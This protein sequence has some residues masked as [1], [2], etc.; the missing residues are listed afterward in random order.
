M[1]YAAKVNNAEVDFGVNMLVNP[2]ELDTLT[3]G[4]I[5]QVGTFQNAAELEFLTKFCLAKAVYNVF[6]PS[7]SLKMSGIE[8]PSLYLPGPNVGLATLVDNSGKFLA[9][10]VQ[11]ALQSKLPGLFQGPL[12]RTIN[13]LLWGRLV[14]PAKRFGFKYCPDWSLDLD[15]PA[16]VMV[17]FSNRNS[18][19]YNLYPLIND[20]L[21][22]NPVVQTD[23]DVNK[24]VDSVLKFY[25]L[26]A[27]PSTLG[28]T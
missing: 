2:S 9:E 14:L 26:K 3:L 28:T 18:F 21:G 1:Q 13:D 17:D 19:A 27:G 5:N 11:G 16:R 15:A 4:R 7:L 20:V 12:R 25:E 8:A 22:G 10:A 6:L 23:T 24:L